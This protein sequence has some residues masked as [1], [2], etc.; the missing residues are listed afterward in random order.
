L[1]QATKGTALYNG[2]VEDQQKLQELEALKAADATVIQTGSPAVQTAPKTARNVVLGFI[3]G[4][5]LGIG[6]AF[7]RESLDTRVR[8]AE[9]IAEQLHLPL[10]ARLPEPPKKLREINHLAMVDDPSGIQAEAFRMFRTNV[11]FA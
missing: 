9:A 3:L 6:L 2:L 10:L 7:L 1:T 8:S 4:L 5:F 11:E